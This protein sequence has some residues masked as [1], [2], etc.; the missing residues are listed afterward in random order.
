MRAMPEL[1]PEVEV[2]R[3]SFFERIAGARIQAVRLGKPLRWPPLGSFC[4]T[5]CA[6]SPFWQSETPRTEIPLLDLSE[7]GWLLLIHLG[8]SGSLPVLQ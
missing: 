3:R 7:G 6:D 2:T 5:H 1:L 4:Q 8:M